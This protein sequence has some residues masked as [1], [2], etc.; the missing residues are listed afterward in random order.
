MT[1]IEKQ[2]KQARSKID[3]ILSE[4]GKVRIDMNLLKGVASQ[5]EVMLIDALQDVNNPEQFNKDIKR[6]IQELKPKEQ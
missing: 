4:I 2:L 3:Q 6:L 5:V 1:G